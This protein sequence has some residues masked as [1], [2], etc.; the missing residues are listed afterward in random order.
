MAEICC[1]MPATRHSWL[2]AAC[3]VA[4]GA[5]VSVSVSASASASASASS[6]AVAAVLSDRE[7]RV[8]A[9]GGR[10]G[11]PRCVVGTQTRTPFAFLVARFLALPRYESR[12]QFSTELCI[13]EDAYGGE[14]ALTH[15]GSRLVM[16][17]SIAGKTI[18]HVYAD[19]VCVRERSLPSPVFG[20]AIC[21][22]TNRLFMGIDGRGITVWS[23]ELEDLHSDFGG[24]A[25]RVSADEA[26]VAELSCN[27]A[28]VAA[29]VHHHTP[30]DVI[31]IRAAVSTVA[32]FCSTTHALKHKHEH[33]EFIVA[34]TLCD[35]GSALAIAC[36]TLHEERMESLKVIAAI[37]GSVLR[38]LPLLAA[39]VFVRT[40]RL[41]CTWSGELVLA[42][43]AVHH[44]SAHM[45]YVYHSD[46]RGAQAVR[47]AIE[48]DSFVRGLA[49]HGDAVVA[50]TSDEKCIFFS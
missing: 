22:V 15:D 24:D 18:L 37:D 36:V 31:D 38:R 8:A 4:E 27:A 11:F 2:K 47:V 25:A 39:N 17:R 10:V 23:L 30:G 3:A 46:Q 12:A 33:K 28:T 9:I 32:L 26:F 41:A 44:R 34:A 21:P 35:S 42:T 49:V 19:S 7:C 43:G 40:T 6:V 5:T 16:A 20:L 50:W 45:I 48:V 1:G 13:T 14:I 29:V